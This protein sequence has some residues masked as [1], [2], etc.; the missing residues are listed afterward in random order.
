M[1]ADKDFEIA[2]HCAADLPSSHQPPNPVWMMVWLGRASAGCH[3][4]A[5]QCREL[6]AELVAMADL[7]EKVT[8]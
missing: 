3:L 2:L 5:D 1:K 6:A 4:S 7:V 8:A